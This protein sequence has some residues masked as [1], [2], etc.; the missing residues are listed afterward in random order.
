MV[1][2]LSP[3]DPIFFLHHANLDRLWDVWTRRQL[4]RDG[5]TLPE[6]A[7]LA[8]WSGEQFLF[9]SDEKGQPVSKTNA[10]YY[11]GMS[12]FDYDYEP[13]SLEEM[14]SRPAIAAAPQAPLSSQRFSA[15]ISSQAIRAGEPAG[16]V[17]EVPGT[18]LQPSDPEMPQQVVEVTVNLKPADQRRRFRILVSVPGG[19]PIE[20]GTITPFGPHASMGLTTFTVPLPANLGAPPGKNVPV[21]IRV[22]P[23]EQAGVAS[24]KG[25][26]A[27]V[28]MAPDAGVKAP[29]G[30]VPQVTAIQVRTN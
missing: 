19:K 13:G 22:V 18:L 16:G 29:I 11:A 23:L 15:R 5:P 6:G 21:D 2:L 9:F 27:P 12:V 26:E 24:G 28:G 25:M 17:A 10:G 1:S 30:A 4:N 14:V 7:D 3:V 8:A 20:A